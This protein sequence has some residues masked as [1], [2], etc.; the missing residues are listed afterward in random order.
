MFS[1]IIL[2]LVLLFA[3]NTVAQEKMDKLVLSG[4]MA[5][6]SHPLIHMIET[7]ALKDVAKKLNLECGII[8]MN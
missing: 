8:R 3:I 4:P 6:V 7:G 5:S 2:G 1:K